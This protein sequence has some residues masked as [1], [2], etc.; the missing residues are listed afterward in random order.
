MG[1]TVLS[2]AA[3]AMGITKSVPKIWV[4]KGTDA[5]ATVSAA[6]YISDAQALGMQ[7]DDVVLYMKT[8]TAALYVHMVTAVSS[9]G[10]TLTSASVPLAN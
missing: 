5:D 6:G 3:I 2:P 7:V 10:A 9:T 8:D 4:L 1:Y